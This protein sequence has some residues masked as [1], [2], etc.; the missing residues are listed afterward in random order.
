MN[1]LAVD[2][3]GF[4]ASI[5]IRQNSVSAGLELEKNEKT[6]QYLVPR[7][8]SLLKSEDLDLENVD[9]FAVTAG[10]GSFTG[11]RIGITTIKSLA[12]VRQKKT[13][14]VNSLA[15]LAE[16]AKGQAVWQS[17]SL[18]VVL[19]AFRQQFFAAV[20]DFDRWEEQS[21]QGDSCTRVIP[22]S[23]LVE[24]VLSENAKLIGAGV[25]CLAKEDCDRIRD[26]VLPHE[27]LGNTA[28]GVAAV[29]NRCF[30]LGISTEPLSLVPNYFRG[31]AA[32][33]KLH[34]S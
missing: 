25:D 2:C 30:E 5:A 15:A 28:M 7:I 6:A 24:L 31:S 22:Q 14:G 13:V 23:E 20:F 29:A 4:S 17:G 10:P 21:V 12:Y 3:S 33:E 32:E 16:C 18:V 19:N 9:G 26:R 1:L 34:G 8:C 11:L 27:Q